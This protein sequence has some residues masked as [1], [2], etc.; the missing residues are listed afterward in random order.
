MSEKS[1]LKKQA[2]SPDAWTEE[3]AA[4]PTA[5]P[6]PEVLDERIN[7]AL[8]AA[9]EKKALHLTTLDL[10]EIATFTDYFVIASGTNLRQVQAISDGVEREL[11]KQLQIHP[12]RIEGYATAEWVLLDYGNVVVH[13]FIDDARAF[14]DLDRL[15]SQA[16]R[17]PVP[18]PKIPGGVIEQASASEPERA[19][20]GMS[21]RRR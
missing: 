6:A 20:S 16:P 17:V 14:Y 11:K 4:A 13:V 12:A 10:R 15:W 1:P 21:R 18:V 19:V 3:K 7:L 8:H 2:L 9:S 5:A